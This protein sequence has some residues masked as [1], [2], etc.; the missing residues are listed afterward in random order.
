LGTVRNRKHTLGLE[1]FSGLYLWALFIIVF[2]IWV[3]DL[4]LTSST[5]HILAAGQSVPAILAV[6]V[7]VP[8]A[9]GQFDLSVG[10]TANLSTIIAIEMQTK[11]HWGMWSAIML[12]IG[13]S[14][15]IGLINGLV[16]VK[17]RVTSFI[18]TLGTAT[19]IGA[20]QVIVTGNVQPYPPASGGWESLAGRDIWGYKIVFLYLIVIVI[21]F[22]WLLDRTP[23]GRYLYALGGNYEASRLS[24]VKV[25]T[26]AWCSLVISATLAGIAG[27]FY[28]SLYGPS[29]IYGQGLLL[30]AFAAVFLGTTQVRPGRPNI[31][32]TVMAV[33]VLA[34]GVIGL[35]YVTGASWLTDM[36]NGVALIV[37]VSFAGWRQRRAVRDRAQSVFK[38]NKTASSVVAAEDADLTTPV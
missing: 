33:F 30:P 26:W 20:V 10:A 14:V 25:D 3:P 19:I 16:V 28:G 7:L 38:R 18:T 8:L 1:R 21:F 4:F 23:F 32:G 5:L 29:L 6:A 35:Q 24:G 12:A 2:A 36:F 17:F 34:T 9:A 27:V 37:A 11:Y 22:W 15:L 31:W 13:V